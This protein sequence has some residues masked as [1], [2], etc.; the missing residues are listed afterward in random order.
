[1]NNRSGEEQTLMTRLDISGDVTD[2]E[3][4]SHELEARQDHNTRLHHWSRPKKIV[5]K[6]VFLSNYQGGIEG[7]TPILAIRHPVTTAARLTTAN[8]WFD[9]FPGAEKQIFAVLVTVG[10]IISYPHTSDFWSR[11]CKQSIRHVSGGWKANIRCACD[12]RK[13]DIIPPY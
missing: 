5:L 6:P 3:W 1:M 8:N 11:V 4:P 2:R 7:L 9:W 12:R 13:D 10:R